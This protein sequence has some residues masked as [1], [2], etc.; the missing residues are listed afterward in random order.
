M[1]AWDLERKRKKG[2]KTGENHDRRLQSESAMYSASVEDKATVFC[3]FVVHD[4]RPPA[5]LIKKPE[6][7]HHVLTSEAQS[8]S[9][10]ALSP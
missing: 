2:G 10:H 3:A 1:G 8:E 4:I 7:D 6:V 5:N 9:V